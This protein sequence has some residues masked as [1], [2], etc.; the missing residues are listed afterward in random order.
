[1]SDETKPDQLP[2]TEDE[3]TDLL[4]AA[5]NFLVDSAIPVPFWKNVAKALRQLSTAAIEWPAVYFEGKIAE[6]RAET[7]ARIKI[8]EENTTQITGQM[9]VPPEY[10]QRAVKKYGEKILREQS[11]LDKIC[12]IAVNLLKK[13]KSASSTDRSADSSE[14]ETISDDFLNSF[15]E[16]ARQKSTEDMQLLFGRIL[17]DEIRKPGRYSIRTVRALGQLDQNTAALFKRL[18][19]VCVAQVYDNQA[20]GYV[21]HAIA[22]S[23]HNLGPFLHNLGRFRYCTLDRYGLNFEQ[24]NILNEYGLII[25]EYNSSH[26][27]SLCVV[28]ENLPVTTPFRHQGRHW[29]LLSSPERDKNQECRVPGV[30]LSRAGCELFPIVDPDP[31]ESYTEDLKKFFAQQSLQMVEIPT[32]NKT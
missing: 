21:H 31:M 25:S 8:I 23:L 13:E 26:D 7:Q 27:Y 24:L 3:T 10:A 20:D 15:E 14:E 2:M 6:K 32:P 5:T 16:E 28:N 4:D 30:A 9:E 22:P 19:S 29:V 12:S 17:A 18:C 1:M 11:N